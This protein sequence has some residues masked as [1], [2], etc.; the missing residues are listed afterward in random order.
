MSL[1]TV[2]AGLSTRFATITGLRCDSSAPATISPPSCFI[3]TMTRRSLVFG[4]GSSITTAEVFICLPK[5][6]EAR[7]IKDL[8]DYADATGSKS[9][10]ASL[11]ADGTLAGAA[12]SVDSVTVSWPVTVEVG[13]VAYTAAQFTIEVLH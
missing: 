5:S 4:T 3:G 1:A 13:G 7:S 9:I 2:R 10:E 12:G 8:D 6:V 11:A